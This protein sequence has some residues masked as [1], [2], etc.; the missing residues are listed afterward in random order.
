MQYVTGKGAPS[1][2]ECAAA[3]FLLTLYEDKTAKELFAEH[4]APKVLATQR[5]FQA[6]KLRMHN[7]PGLFRLMLDDPI[8]QGEIDGAAGE[9]CEEYLK[10]KRERQVHEGNH[11]L[12]Q[13]L[14]SLP[15]EDRERVQKH[16]VEQVKFLLKGKKM[17]ENLMRTLAK[18]ILR[19]AHQRWKRLNPRDRT[20]GDIIAGN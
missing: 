7:P 4:K 1:D 15:R 3:A 20:I 11:E 12:R 18:G 9:M 8:P 13:W 14:E 2:T 10:R 19:K 5:R 6:K 17:S 16:A